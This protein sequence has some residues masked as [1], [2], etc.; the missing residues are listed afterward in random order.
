MWNEFVRWITKR[1]GL[2][3]LL[4]INIVLFVLVQVVLIFQRLSDVSV[5]PSD[6][7]LA[8][9]AGVTGLVQRPW[10][11]ITHMFVHVEVGHFI[12]NIF[13]LYTAGK[14]F[15]HFLGDGRLVVNYILGGMFGYL[16]YLGMAMIFPKLTGASYILG[17]SA[18]IMS[19]LLTI[20]ILQPNYQIKL[21]GV[22][23][24]KLIWLC[25]I[26]IL[27]DLISLRKGF[28]SGGHV[29]HL[30]GAIFGVIYAYQFK[31]GVVM[32][33]WL[34]NFFKRIGSFF[35]GSKNSYTEHRRPKS[36]EEFNAEKKKRQQ[37]VDQ[38]LD[39]ISKS[40]YESLSKEE[41]DFLFKYS[42]K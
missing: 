31:R 19:I 20:G 5:I 9:G 24:M 11:V 21:F 40:G 42:Q 22:F 27:V 35:S 28:N 26:I 32:G 34:E 12:F 14:L 16:L 2:N 33:S 15:R 37:R 18:S 3:R 4:A 41:K 39:K 1:D 10:S 17:A 25:G 23:D 38:I 36:D 29:A 30:G 8:A 6:L 7:Y 13:C